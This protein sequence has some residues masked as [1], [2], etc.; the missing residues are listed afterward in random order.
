[1]A[2]KSSDA[3]IQMRVLELKKARI[4]GFG[5][6]DMMQYCK[7][8]WGITSK[9]TVSKY[10]KLV[11]DSLAEDGKDVV[12]AMRAEQIA[13]YK[14]ILKRLYPRLFHKVPALDEKGKPILDSKKQPTYTD[15][16]NETPLRLYIMTCRRL[17][18]IEGTESITH[19]LEGLINFKHADVAL[20]DDDEKKYEDNLD[21]VL[22]KRKR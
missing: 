14:D 4:Q 3:Q 15:K 8:R 7:Q 1:M 18:R 17:D 20:S 11:A 21:E 12:E 10:L 19:R 9:R 16:E 13:R 5:Y 6:S 2:Q 22:G